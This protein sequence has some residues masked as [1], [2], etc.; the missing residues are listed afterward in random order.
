MSHR[1]FL[2][3]KEIASM[4]GGQVEI[5]P[6][7]GTQV[8]HRSGTSL[9]VTEGMMLAGLSEAAERIV[10]WLKFQ[11]A[12]GENAPHAHRFARK[13]M[14]ARVRSRRRGSLS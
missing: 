13:L 11:D 1:D 9:Q 8:L 7:L 12:I 2:A 10:A 6:T 5:H 4:Y 3:I 14:A